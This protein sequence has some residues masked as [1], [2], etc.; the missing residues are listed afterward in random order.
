MAREPKHLTD[1]EPPVLGRLG[2][3]G[4]STKGQWA[5]VVYRGTPQRKKTATSITCA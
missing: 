5:E 2:D 3:R 1:A 4:T